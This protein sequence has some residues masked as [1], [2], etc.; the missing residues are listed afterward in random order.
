MDDRKCIASRALRQV[1]GDPYKQSVCASWHSMSVK[2]RRLLPVHEFVETIKNILQDCRQKNGE[3]V[4]FLADFAI[5]TNIIASYAFV[6]LPE[7]IDDLYVVAYES[8][9]FE[10][11]AEHANGPQISSIISTVYGLIDH[12]GGDFLDGTN[13]AE[14]VATAELVDIQTRK[15]MEQ[16]GPKSEC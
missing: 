2:I 6:E 9:I 12:K 14:G 16:V 10:L 8:G 11:V 1:C 4:R 5:R 15:G 13:C 7:D 3:Y